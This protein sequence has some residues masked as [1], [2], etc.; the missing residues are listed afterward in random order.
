MQRRYDDCTYLVDGRQEA[1]RVADD[2]A[3]MASGAE[4][5]WEISTT[6]MKLLPHTKYY[7][8]KG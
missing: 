4:T 3:N 5:F 1:T 8:I 6:R 2:G 7:T